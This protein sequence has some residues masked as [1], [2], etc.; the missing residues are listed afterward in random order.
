MT[1]PFKTITT[2]LSDRDDKGKFIKNHPKTGGTSF[3]K[4]QRHT[5]MMDFSAKVNWLLYQLNGSVTN[6]TNAKYQIVRTEM[7]EKLSPNSRAELHAISMEVDA[8]VE[9]LKDLKEKVA[10]FSKTKKQRTV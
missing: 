9:H 10:K 2:E 6:I 4:G 5:P 1:D 3:Y 8:L 7:A